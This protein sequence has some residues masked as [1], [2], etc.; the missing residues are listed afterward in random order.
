MQR[1]RA[2]KLGA[3]I[4]VRL[5][6]HTL[7]QMQSIASDPG[8][9]RIDDQVSLRRPAI[10]KNADGHVDNNS[11]VR[12]PERRVLLNPPA[13]RLLECCE[14]ALVADER[15]DERMFDRHRQ[16]IGSRNQG[17]N[18]AIGSLIERVDLRT[19]PCKIFVGRHESPYENLL[20]SSG[21]CGHRTIFPNFRRLRSRVDSAYMLESAF[22]WGYS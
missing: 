5:A 21:L 19:G 8:V 18:R 4:R 17:F 13:H 14:I 15:L 7:V 12:N 6:V 2:A 9:N 16:A 1:L 11:S 3:G 20:V 22:V 10:L